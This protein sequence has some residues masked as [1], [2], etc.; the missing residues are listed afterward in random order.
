[1]WPWAGHCPLAFHFS[2]RDGSDPRAAGSSK[3]ALPVQ[4]VHRP[5][6]VPSVNSSALSPNVQTLLTASEDCCVYGWETQSGR[7][8]W[9]RGGHTGPVKFCRFSPDGRLFASTSCDCTVRLW[10]AAEAKCLQVL[11]GHQRSV[12]TVSFSPDSKQL[13]SGG[14]DKQVML[15]EVQVRPMRPSLV[16]PGCGLPP[17]ASGSSG[18]S[19][20][21]GQMLR[22]LVGHRDSIQSSDFA[23]NS[24]SLATGS[25]DSTIRIWD[26]RVGA[27]AA[28]HKE[29][30]GHKGNISCL[31]Y[32]AS[33]LLASGSWDKTIHIWN[34]STTRLLVQLKGHTS[35][36]KSIAF[37]P[38]ERQLASA[39]Y[40][41]MVKVWDCST[42]KCTET[43]KGA[44]DVPHTC[45]FTHDGR[46]L[47]SG[48]AEG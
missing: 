17:T 3:D 35:W 13:A 26:L 15:W 11:K 30:E 39:G 43:L 10:D 6:T 27:P 29:L 37:S 32:S 44:L 14:W 20:Q 45:T 8:L 22:H 5:D 41:G 7:L 33:G 38:D 46:L 25:W 1:M 9:R 48:A 42:G 34:S 36:V 40:S 19:F 23:P 18:L 4:S 31:C 2:P 12:E 21:S 24:E 28:V 16:G 47:V